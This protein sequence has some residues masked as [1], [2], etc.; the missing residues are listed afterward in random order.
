MGS[1]WG[2][3]SNYAFGAS[4]KGGYL[5]PASPQVAQG[6]AEGQV[7][8][9]CILA[10]EESDQVKKILILDGDCTSL[11]SPRRSRASAFEPWRHRRAIQHVA[12]FLERLDP[13]LVMQLHPPPPAP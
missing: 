12:Q 10:T 4:D 13:V 9:V 6:S 8:C 7:K 5:T 2:L 11:P 1:G 3:T